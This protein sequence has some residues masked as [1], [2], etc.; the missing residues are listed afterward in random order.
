MKRKTPQN[1]SGTRIYSETNFKPIIQGSY[2]PSA[3]VRVSAAELL[4]LSRNREEA[5]FYLNDSYG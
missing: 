1:W 5:F 4:K 2:P 3:L